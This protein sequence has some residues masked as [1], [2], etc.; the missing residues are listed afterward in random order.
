M[1]DGLSNLNLLRIRRTDESFAAS[2]D[3]L[4]DE[5]SDT[6]AFILRTC[7]RLDVLTTD[8]DAAAFPNQLDAHFAGRNAVRE[9][10]RVATGLDSKIVGE[11][12]ILGQVRSTLRDATHL[13]PHVRR[14]VERSIAVGRAVREA[15]GIGTAGQ[16]Y[17][18]AAIAF[19]AQ[20]ELASGAIG[21]VGSGALGR[22]LAVAV[23][24]NLERR[25]VVFGRHCG[26]AALTAAFAGGRAA[27]LGEI[28]CEAPHLAAIVSATSSP[29]TLITAE[30]LALVADDLPIV[31]L[32][33]PANVELTLANRIGLA[34]LVEYGAQPREPIVER[35]ES[36]VAAAADRYVAAQTT[37]R[38]RTAGAFI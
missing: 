26:R 38:V 13:Q 8:N 18:G 17:V 27:S 2:A 21:I 36:L 33:E 32:G 10:F 7:E 6:G 15:S 5:V 30:S 29:R 9:L 14:V 16:G 12:H 20:Q 23:A 34:D 31:D 11:S 37:R 28:R 3:R 35:A 22:E 4:A 25:V 1:S 19:L 24:E